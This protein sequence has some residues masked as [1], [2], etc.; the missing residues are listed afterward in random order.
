MK[1]SNLPKMA[2]LKLFDRNGKLTEKLDNF[3]IVT[4]KYVMSVLEG[5]EK[6]PVG[7]TKDNFLFALKNSRIIKL[8]EIERRTR[9]LEILNRQLDWLNYTIDKERCG[10]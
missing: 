4:T 3:D 7:V 2:Q 8:R 9:E 6:I 10:E 5:T 1:E